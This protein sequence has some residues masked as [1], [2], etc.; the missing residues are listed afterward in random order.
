M[1][2]PRGIGHDGRARGTVGAIAVDLDAERMEE[3]HGE[4]G[5]DRRQGRVYFGDDGVDAVARVL[6]NQDVSKRQGG[7]AAAVRGVRMLR[8]GAL[9]GPAAGAAS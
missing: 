9:N 4:H 8:I 3:R 5:S 6:A 1:N 7:F 2:A